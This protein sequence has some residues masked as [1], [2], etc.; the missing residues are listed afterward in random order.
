[1]L[2]LDCGRNPPWL[3]SVAHGNGKVGSFGAKRPHV[4]CPGAEWDEGGGGGVAVGIQNVHRM[5]GLVNKL[6]NIS[7]L[8]QEMLHLLIFQVRYQIDSFLHV[9]ALIFLNTIRLKA[10]HG[11]SIDL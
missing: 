4:T 1:M 11:K 8:L 5:I 3:K 9:L 7:L 6:S 2:A 10:I